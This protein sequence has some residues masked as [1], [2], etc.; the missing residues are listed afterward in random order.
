MSRYFLL[1]FFLVNIFTILIKCDDNKTENITNNDTEKVDMNHM[2]YFEKL[3]T[4]LDEKMGKFH[5][6]PKD[7]PKYYEDA[8]ERKDSFI[9]RLENKIDSYGLGNST[10]IKKA[11]FK[12]I[13]TMLFDEIIS[14][15]FFREKV[16]EEIDS[17]NYTKKKLPKKNFSNEVIKFFLNGIF[18]K[19]LEG[20]NDEVDVEDI[21]SYF[22]VEKLASIL[23][24]LL[25]GLKNVGIT[26]F[27]SGLLGLFNKTITNYNKTE[28]D[29]NLKN[30]K[31]QE[32][33][34]DL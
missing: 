8:K 17:Y 14:E 26:D 28:N 11:Q 21:K 24:D 16:R 22:K 13:L 5:S 20:V 2:T 31:K 10:K 18:D 15:S 30:R 6:D 1:L 32:K 25:G 33:S 3:K 27:F 19:F 9:N 7:N 12:E 23:S 29:D 4:H 34:S